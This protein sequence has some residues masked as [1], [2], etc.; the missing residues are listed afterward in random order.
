MRPASPF[1]GGLVPFPGDD[2]IWDAADG[3]HIASV[4]GTQLAPQETWW[5]L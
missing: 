2:Q 5:A 1:L 4:Q 3:Q